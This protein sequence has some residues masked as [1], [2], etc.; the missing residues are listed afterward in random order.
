MS[1][2]EQPI[3]EWLALFMKRHK[4]ELWGAADLGCNEGSCGGKGSPTSVRRIERVKLKSAG[5]KRVES[6][7]EGIKGLIGELMAEHIF[8]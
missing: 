6:A 2:S 1:K 4:I 8:D 7:E 5:H 3:P